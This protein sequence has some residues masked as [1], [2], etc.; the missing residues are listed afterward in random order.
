MI[1]PKNKLEIGDAIP[2]RASKAVQ[3]EIVTLADNE[4]HYILKILERTHWRISGPKGAAKIL[5]INRTT[6]EARMKRLGIVR[7]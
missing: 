1:S 5:D 4:R 6:L 3:D 2:K 7:P